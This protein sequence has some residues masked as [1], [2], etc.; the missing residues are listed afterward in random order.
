MLLQEK[1]I[2]LL[3]SRQLKPKERRIGGRS[4][5]VV[6]LN[7]NY[8]FTIREHK[9]KPGYLY[10][11]LKNGDVLTEWVELDE[12]SLPLAIDY[13]NSFNRPNIKPSLLSKRTLFLWTSIICFLILT[14]MSAYLI[15]KKPSTCNCQ[16]STSS[17]K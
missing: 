14:G 5:L 13:V 1:V 8:T 16:Q 11:N 15:A 6:K 4:D 2:S 12:V 17:L 10:A 9:I 3:E 7:N